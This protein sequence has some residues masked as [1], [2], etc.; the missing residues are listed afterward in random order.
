MFYPNVNKSCSTSCHFLF[1]TFDCQD[2]NFRNIFF[3]GWSNLVTKKNCANLTVLNRSGNSSI[4]LRASAWSLTRSL[5]TEAGSAQSVVLHQSRVDR[6]VMIPR[7]SR[8]RYRTWVLKGLYNIIL[9][10][11]S[12]PFFVICLSTDLCVYLRLFI[13]VMWYGGIQELS[14]HIKSERKKMLEAFWI[15]L[16]QRL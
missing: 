14:G 8:V 16:L 5:F 3:W 9:K 11:C 7:G 4:S 10:A 12:W 2:L 13:R 15:F 1:T 6:E